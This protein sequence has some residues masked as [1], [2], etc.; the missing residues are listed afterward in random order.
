MHP[1]NIGDCVLFDPDTEAE[2]VVALVRR[3]AHLVL[4]P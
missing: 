1:Q 3:E 4:L 2:A